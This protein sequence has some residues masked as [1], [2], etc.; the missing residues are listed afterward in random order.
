MLRCGFSVNPL[1]RLSL[2]PVEPISSVRIAEQVPD[3]RCSVEA[4]VVWTRMSFVPVALFMA[5]NR[6]AFALDA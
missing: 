5:W 1:R 2:L 3:Q 6:V 4:A